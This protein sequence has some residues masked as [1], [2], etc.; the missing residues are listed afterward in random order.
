LTIWTLPDQ[1]SSLPGFDVLRAIGVPALLLSGARSTVPQNVEAIDTT[2]SD[3]SKVTRPIPVPNELSKPFWDAARQHVLAMQRCQ[4]CGHF[5]HP[6]YPTCVN[7][8]GIDLKFEPVE[9]KGAIYAYTIMY[10]V[11]D[12]RFAS[13]VPYASIIVELDQAPG[14]LMAG[15][16]LNA[17]YTEAKV[18]RR[19]EVT[20]EKLTDEI[21]LPQF[22]LASE[23]AS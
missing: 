15:N 8:M 6:P 23:T 19:V 21:T 17:P 3:W 12:K 4:S 1:D 2:M 7:C 13:A 16:L 11:G 14:T 5:Q 20:F 18:G 22:R 10:H 9:G